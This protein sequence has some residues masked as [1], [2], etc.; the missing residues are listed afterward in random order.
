MKYGLCIFLIFAMQV[1]GMFEGE[2]LPELP[3]LVEPVG[4][5]KPFDRAAGV[6]TLAE[7][8][9][10]AQQNQQLRSNPQLLRTIQKQPVVVVARQVH[11]QGVAGTEAEK[12]ELTLAQRAAIEREGSSTSFVSRVPKKPAVPLTE[13]QKQIQRAENIL[14]SIVKL[15]NKLHN[16]EFYEEALPLAE[17]QLE[18]VIEFESKMKKTN[19]DEVTKSGLQEKIAAVKALLEDTIQHKTDQAAEQR[20]AEV[21]ARKLLAAQKEAARQQV[22]QEEAQRVALQK[23][24]ETYYADPAVQKV[25][26]KFKKIDSVSLSDL[27]VDLEVLGLRDFSLED[28]LAHLLDGSPEK[29]QLVRV[30]QF[31][32]AAFKRLEKEAPSFSMVKDTFLDLLGSTGGRGVFRK[33]VEEKISF[34]QDK[35]I[36]DRLDTVSREY[37]QGAIVQFHEGVQKVVEMLVYPD[38]RLVESLEKALSQIESQ[39][40]SNGAY[41]QQ[42]E[43]YR[44]LRQVQD[45]AEILRHIVSGISLP[46][47]FARDTYIAQFRAF[48]KIAFEKNSSQKFLEEN[49]SDKAIALAIEK[50][51]S[52]DFAVGFLDSEEPVYRTLGQQVAGKVGKEVLVIP[53]GS[54]T[55]AHGY[56]LSEVNGQQVKLAFEGLI[57]ELGID[58]SILTSEPED[59]HYIPYDFLEK[60][61]DAWLRDFASKNDSMSSVVRFKKERVLCDA[62]QEARMGTYGVGRIDIFRQIG[63]E[64]LAYP[65]AKSLQL[66]NLK[67]G[68]LVVEPFAPAQRVNAERLGECFPVVKGVPDGLSIEET[69]KFIDGSIDEERFQ[70][71]LEEQS[72]KMDSERDFKK[73]RSDL[74]IFLSV[75][76]GPA[77]AGVGFLENMQL[78]LSDPERI[79]QMIE[80]EQLPFVL[81]ELTAF[82]QSVLQGKPVND[83]S[84][85]WWQV[86]LYQRA[87]LFKQT[88]SELDRATLSLDRLSEELLQEKVEN[89]VQNISVVLGDYQ[90]ELIKQRWQ[91]RELLVLDQTKRFP[92]QMKQWETW[93]TAL[94]GKKTFGSDELLL[95]R[96]QQ[97]SLE[98][99]LEQVPLLLKQVSDLIAY[100]P[101]NKN[102]K[103][104][105]AYKKQLQDAQKKYAS[106]LGLWNKVLADNP[107]VEVAEPATLVSGYQRKAQAL[108]GKLARLNKM[109][110]WQELNEAYDSALIKNNGIKTELLNRLVDAKKEVEQLLIDTPDLL[111]QVEEYLGILVRSTGNDEV[112]AQLKNDRDQLIAHEKI[113]DNY[114]KKW[115]VVLK[116]FG[117]HK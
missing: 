82:Q 33:Q 109:S 27:V 53:L 80:Q 13:M 79:K 12:G 59:W 61:G 54:C 15:T 70:Q 88:V 32:L 16:H 62:W 64:L 115:D 113:Y 20:A 67:L 48:E 34:L 57:K 9:R 94:K 60:I 63:S 58:S 36:M 98:Q 68:G 100:D 85:E 75:K 72:L 44:S 2:R 52:P 7:Q 42:N 111:E 96:E 24:V 90:Q 47:A 55:N 3:S 28:V 92:A 101:K 83:F 51:L 19:A 84:H 39:A 21:Q 78:A 108:V 49:P 107:L 81:K 11:P 4:G 102:I 71:Q 86:E 93:N 26:E 10:I 74:S 23:K 76:Q 110:A 87:E 45:S 114:V 8:Q 91:Q 5:E 35:E 56:I 105:K 116:K 117:P 6:R 66:K 65:L 99:F 25:L 22:L 104:F 14:V 18:A 50:V 17:E 89:F 40:G 43:L 1:G 103:K 77:R 69:K 95:L 112:I 30:Q 38:E 46:S 106:Y 73:G 97:Q 31:E 41:N 37:V 29:A